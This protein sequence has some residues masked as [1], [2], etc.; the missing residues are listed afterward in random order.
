MKK[1]KE[2]E[3][4]EKR[5]M[6]IANSLY[7]LGVDDDVITAITKIEMDQVLQFRNN[8]ESKKKQQNIDSQTKKEI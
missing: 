7:E 8:Q 6:Q 4:Y 2:Q 5:Q 3:L 1:S